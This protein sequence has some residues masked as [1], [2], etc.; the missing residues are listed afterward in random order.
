METALSRP[1]GEPQTPSG[2]AKSR[3]A[4]A[5]RGDLSRS[6]EMTQR[7]PAPQNEWL[8]TTQRLTWPELYRHDGFCGWEY[9]RPPQDRLSGFFLGFDLDDE[10]NVV[11]DGA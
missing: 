2:R 5:L 8:F 7:R 4:D 6:Q 9:I 11:S 10:I 1:E 3:Y